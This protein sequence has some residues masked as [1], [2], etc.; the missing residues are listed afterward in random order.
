MPAT[1]PIASE[2]AASISVICRLAQKTGFAS[3]VNKA[4]IIFVSDGTTSPKNKPDRERNSQMATIT[5]AT[6]TRT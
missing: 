5:R 1:A 2:A 3:R 6:T 4:G